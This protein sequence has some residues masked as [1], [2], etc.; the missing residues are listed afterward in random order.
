MKMPAWR[1]TTPRP[2]QEAQVFT[3]P[4]PDLE[5]VEEQS[6]QD[7]YFSISS[8]FSTPSAAKK[9]TKWQRLALEACKQCGQNWLPKVEEASNLSSWL[10]SR[11]SIDLELIAALSPDAI[12][13]GPKLIELSNDHHLH[14]IRLYVG[15]EGDFSADEYAQCSRQGMIPIKLGDLVLKVE[16]AVIFSLSNLCALLRQ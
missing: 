1:A 16:T 13:L 2:P 5:P 12:A 4:L 3:P 6:L 9:A 15:P 11:D 7:T 14:S 10:P 8:S